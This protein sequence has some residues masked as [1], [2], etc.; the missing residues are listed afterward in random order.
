MAQ[1]R[2]DVDHIRVQV[3]RL[4]RYMEQTA[5]TSVSSSQ[6]APQPA[7]QPMSRTDNTAVHYGRPLSEK[8]QAYLARLHQ[9]DNAFAVQTTTYPSG[10]SAPSVPPAT[11][12][13]AHPAPVRDIPMTRIVQWIAHDWPMKVGGFLVIAAVG[14]FITY[15]ALSDILSPTGR[16]IFGYV[17]TALCLAFGA[18][19]ADTHRAQGNVFLVIGGAAM[20]ITTLGGMYLD[21]VV[22]TVGL[23][24]MLMAVGLLSL[25]A[26]RQKSK[27]LMVTVICFGAVIPGFFFNDASFVT[28]FI[29]LF[30]LS[31]GTLWIVYR[32]EWR[33]LTLL[34]MITVMT[35][36]FGY[37]GFGDG[38]SAEQLTNLL[39]AMLF[40]ILFFGV[41]VAAMMRA[42]KPNSIDVIT[43]LLLGFLVWMWT[44]MFA[45][46][47]I[48][49]IFLLIGAALLFASASY[50]IFVRTRHMLP[51]LVYGGVSVMLLAVAT[52]IQFDGPVLVT[53][54]A[55][56]AATGAIIALK[57]M[58]DKLSSGV[59]AVIVGAYAVPVLLSLDYIDRA[60]YDINALF[61]MFMLAMTALAVAIAA[62][63]VA[64]V[65][66]SPAMRI[67]RL[68]AYG[69]GLYVVLLVWYAAHFFVGDSD[70][71]TFVALLIYTVSGVMFY[72]SGMREQSRPLRVV[73][74]LLFAVVILRVLLVEFWGMD[75]VMRIITSFVI[76][77]LLISTAFLRQSR[78]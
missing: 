4:V 35:Y 1:L 54:F 33:V 69:G 70:V 65:S 31:M 53:A 32:T 56:E 23:F 37:M 78:Q 47:D 36:S 12:P 41:N 67:G 52:A 71:A 46:E 76:G 24:L 21:V 17:F 2:A 19:R 25:L 57:V 43:A 30:F 61:A 38:A 34:L 72:V 44:V 55:V 10:A 22:P 15:A 73:G 51:T 74:G 42:Q 60:A 7:S 6:P 77:M 58:R 40:T 49:Q 39:T 3:D 66:A 27:A 8:E 29:Y 48:V 18:A 28:I 20:L 59:S 68:F 63:R 14:W 75:I 9:N 13:L 50:G 62:F 64:R 16:V 11:P 45:D 5:P 26:L